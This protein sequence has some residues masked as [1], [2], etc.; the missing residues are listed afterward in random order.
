M[1]ANQEKAP[2][3]IVVASPFVIILLG[4]LTATL[5]SSF[6]AEWA[7]VPLALIYWTLMGI[8]IWKFKGKLPLHKWFKR[9]EKAPLWITLTLLIGS[10]PL[11]ILLSS[12]QLFDSM[13]LVL[14]WLLFACVN[15]WFEEFYWRGVLLDRLLE[16]WPVSLAIGFTTALFVVSHPLMWGVF[17]YANQSYHLYLYLAVA[18][19]VWAI[20]YL[21]TRSLRVVIFFSYH[22]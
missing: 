20:T 8:F 6:I 3:W 1:F 16:K 17:S 12:Y 18:G 22:R 5:F 13:L 2:F 7:W 21:K 14:L 19:I 11:T 4:F 9:S 10:F 15:P